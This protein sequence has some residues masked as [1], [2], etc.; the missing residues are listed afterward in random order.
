MLS[1]GINAYTH[2]GVEITANSRVAL[3]VL[4][5]QSR[6][7]SVRLNKEPERRRRSHTVL[8]C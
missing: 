7:A 3:Y 8:A 2:I 6:Q 4:P 1:P 5:G